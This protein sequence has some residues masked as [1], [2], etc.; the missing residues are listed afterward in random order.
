MCLVPSQPDASGTCLVLLVTLALSRPR[1]LE[2][3]PVPSWTTSRQIRP[4]AR[5]RLALLP[6]VTGCERN[7]PSLHPGIGPCVRCV[8]HLR[9]AG[10]RL[11][12]NTL[13]C[14][15]RLFPL[16][17]QPP[18]RRARRPRPLQDMRGIRVRQNSAAATPAPPANPNP[19]PTHTP[20]RSW[21]AYAKRS[22]AQ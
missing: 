4:C 7:L 10:H 16:T 6:H 21:N 5:N 8:L 18:V 20:P 12:T 1:R 17:Q 9:R 14:C 15:R 22:G 11:A 19:S 2:N 3:C 13:P